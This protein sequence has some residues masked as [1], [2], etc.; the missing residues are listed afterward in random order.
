MAGCKQSREFLEG[1]KD[2]FLILT[3]GCAQLDLLFRNEENFVGDVNLNGSLVCS[4]HEIMKLKIL[5]GV[6]KAST[7]AQ[8]LGFRRAD[9][10]LSKSW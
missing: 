8:T 6:K 9:F 1:V 5:W 10:G 2:S 4:D 3:A 7:G